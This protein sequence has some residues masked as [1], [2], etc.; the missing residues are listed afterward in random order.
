VF[1]YIILES[2]ILRW[3]ADYRDIEGW[4]DIA[5]NW[6]VVA[7]VVSV[8]GAGLMF[9]IKWFKKKRAGVIR[10]E[11]WSRGET[12]LLILV[13]LLPI[14]V[15]LL[16]TWYISRDYPNIIGVGGLFKGVMVSWFLY[17]LLMV[18]GHALS[19]WRH[20]LL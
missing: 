9:F 3:F 4:D 12:L 16:A 5:Q 15:G 18:I 14:F 2:N 19:P 6:L 13:G 1:A 7:A 20:E 8:L 11:A 10:L 17:V